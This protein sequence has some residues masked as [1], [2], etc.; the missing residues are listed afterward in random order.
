MIFVSL[1]AAGFVFNTSLPVHAESL[2]AKIQKGETLYNEEKYDEALKEFLD[3]QVEKPGDISLKYNIG[4]THFQMRNFQEAEESFWAVANSDLPELQQSAF[5]NLGNCAYRQG[6]LED[7]VNYYKQALELD[8]KDEDARYNLEFVRREI[9]RRLE[10]AKKREQE[11]NQSCQN[12]QQQ[13]QEQGESQ[14]KKQASAS[15]QEN[16]NETEQREQ[17][18]EE[19]NRQQEEEARQ[20]QAMQPAEQSKEEP[21]RDASSS[22]AAAMTDKEMSP[23]E[24]QRWLN[25]LDEEQKELA[26]EQIRKALSGQEFR[27]DKDW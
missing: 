12:P 8:S 24:A 11:Q 10:E 6:K 23:Q 1:F 13:Q 27:T 22:Q 4:N 9:K 25:T 15:Q 21:P 14:E 7:A 26:K 18:Q 16:G 2:Y 20:Q 3:A 5:Y 19:Q 17:K